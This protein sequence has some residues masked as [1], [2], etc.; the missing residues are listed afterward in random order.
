MTTPERKHLVR[1]FSRRDD[2]RAAVAALKLS[3]A[4]ARELRVAILR[5]RAFGAARRGAARRRP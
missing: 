5:E 4:E 2:W 1:D 3:E